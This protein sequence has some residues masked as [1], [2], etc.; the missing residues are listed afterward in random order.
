MSY[1]YSQNPPSAD[2]LMF[3]TKS[4][5]FYYLDLLG[6]KNDFPILL[7][8]YLTMMLSVWSIWIAGKV[9]KFVKNLVAR[10]LKL[11]GNTKTKP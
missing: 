6:E 3:L 5:F 2:G 4:V 1:L 9:V 7:L 8:T 11:L 10:L